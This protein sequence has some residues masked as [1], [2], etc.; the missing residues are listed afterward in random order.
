MPQRANPLAG[1]VHVGHVEEL[2]LLERRT[3]ELLDDRPGVSPLDLETPALP[4][5]GLPHG[6]H[7]RASIRLDVEVPVSADFPVIA[8]PVAGRRSADEEELVLALSEQDTVSDHVAVLVD[9][10]VL[11]RNVDVEVRDAV[12]RGVTNQLDGVGAAND[13]VVH[14]VRLIEE[15]GRFAPGP[16]L[17]SPTRVFGRHHGHDV[18]GVLGVAQNVDDVGASID[19]VLQTP[20]FGL[21]HQSF[22]FC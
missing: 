5:D 21:R 9:G 16:L 10:H 12:D 1:D 8:Q 11:L 6:V 4:I 18:G 17:Q 19:N 3:V 22:A 15:H 14:V 2:E 20:W 7:R 13:H